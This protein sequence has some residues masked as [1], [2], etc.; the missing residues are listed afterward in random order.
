MYSPK[1]ILGEDGVLAKHIKGFSPRPAQ[2][3]MAEIVLDVIDAGQNLIAEAGTGTGK[4]FAYLVPAILSGRKTIIST[5]TKNLQ[6]QLYGRDLPLIR[7]A[8]TVPVSV[9]LLKGRSNYLCLHRL[10]VHEEEIKH[11]SHQQWKDVQLIQKWSAQT[12][13]GDLAEC[14]PLAETDPIWPK[15]TSTVDNCLGQD[16]DDFQHCFLTRARREAQAADIVVINHYLLL[17]DMALRDEGYGELLPD[18]DVYIIDEAHQLAE[19]ANG[20][21]GKRLSSFQLTELAS[22]IRAEYRKDINESDDLLCQADKLETLV[23]DARLAL[24]TRVSRQSWPQ[25]RDK[26][27]LVTALE[28]ISALLQTLTDALQPLSERSKG[29]DNCHKRAIELHSRLAL[30]MNFQ[31]TENVYWLDA[32]RRSFSLHCTPLQIDEV[33]HQHQQSRGGSWIFTSAT[34]AIGEDL[35]YFA[36]QLGITE[37]QSHCW[38]S[39]FDYR[40]QALLYLPDHMPEPNTPQYLDAFVDAAV[41]VL[42]ASRGRAFVLFTS[43]RAL[44]ACAPL[45]EARLDFPLFKQGDAPRDQ[46]LSQFRQTANAVLL[47]CQSFWEGVD[48]R[49]DALSCVIIDKLPFASPDDPIL[50][51]RLAMLKDRGGNPFMD[52]QVPQAVIALKQGVG[53]LIRDYN[54]TG[55]IMIADPRLLKKFYGKRILRSLPPAPISRSLDEVRN[56]YTVVNPGSEAVPVA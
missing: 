22:D 51:A 12:R 6:D 13:S 2:Q 29:L 32:H 39:P 38:P 19:V 49:G 4:T 24:G 53:R 28:N 5:G 33:F 31:D 21:F 3:E 46:L 9:A 48:V 37:A 26:Q 15:V 43:H 10:R 36:R 25:L 30:L 7:D 20:F 23:K 47:G 40:A 44:E 45:F 42:Q 18:S 8:L 17:A 1:D 52:Y 34:L 50:Q 16:C 14:S 27:Q 54:D 55:V 35:S 41:P 11:Q 56:F